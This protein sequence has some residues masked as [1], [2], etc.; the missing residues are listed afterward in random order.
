MNQCTTILWF[1]NDLRLDDNAAL[2]AALA[3]G[4]NVI[5][6]FIWDPESEGDWPTGGA[7]RCWLHGSLSNLDNALR[8]AG[9]RLVI[10]QG[11]SLGVLLRLLDET[12]ADA[13]FWNRRYEPATIARDKQIKVVLR[14]RGVTA[15]SY[16]S[17]ILFE[18]WTV[19]TKS[20][21]PYRVFSPFYRACLSLPEPDAPLPAP[22]TIAALG[23]WPTSSELSELG[24]LPPIPWDA[25]IRSTWSFGEAASNTRLA[26]FLSQSLTGYLDARDRPD[27]D[28]TS[29][30]SAY[31]HFGELSPRRVWHTVREVLQNRKQKASSQCAEGFLRQLVWREF[32]HHLLFHFPH[33]P[34]APL[35][36]SFARFPWRDDPK[37]LKAWQQGK[38]GYPFVDAGMRQLW[39]T[40]WMHNRVRMVVGSFLVKDLLIPWQSGARWFWDTLVDADL[41]NNTMGWQWVAGCGADAAPFFRIF[42][43]VSQ[44]ER[45]DP[46]GVYVRQWVPELAKL[47][48]RWIHKPWQAPQAV[49]QEAGVTLGKSYPAPMVDH[50]EARKKALELLRKMR[51]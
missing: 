51:R 31:L 3:R 13:V 30:L 33:T 42:N 46:N 12:N 5:P 11:K 4:R 9:S 40:G 15:E 18:P 39:T 10:R 29:R 17:A 20:S 50:D 25:S 45:C 8:E 2:H 6:L 43:P 28:G 16:N 32:A 22:K 1:R 14:E 23:Q 47:P 38:T 36:Q 37:A 44:G 48:D 49:L 35:N 24:L 41:A 34:T 7:S 26:D 19:Q 21:T 27:V